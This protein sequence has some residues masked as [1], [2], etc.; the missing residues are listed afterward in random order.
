MYK[1]RN[2]K[3]FSNAEARG[4]DLCMEFTFLS[5][6]MHQKQSQN[7][8]ISFLKT[9][10]KVKKVI[11][12]VFLNNYYLQKLFRLAILFPEQLEFITFVFTILFLAIKHFLLTFSA[13]KSKDTNAIYTLV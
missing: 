3:N 12:K 10:Y 9:T 7:A 5:K 1:S 6:N 2:F 13:F 8:Y 4:V 11:L